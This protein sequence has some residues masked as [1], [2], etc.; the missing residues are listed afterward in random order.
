[1]SQNINIYILLCMPT[2]PNSATV[3]ILPQNLHIYLVKL[4]FAHQNARKH[5][6]LHAFVNIAEPVT[7]Y[8]FLQ[9]LVT[10]RQTTQKTLYFLPPPPV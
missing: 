8:H 2:R 10:S 3:A 7:K 4:I 9:H 6:Y 5:N 1:M